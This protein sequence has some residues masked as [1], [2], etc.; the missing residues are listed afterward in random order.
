[1]H[2]R[3]SV[4]IPFMGERAAPYVPIVHDFKR[5]VHRKKARMKRIAR[6]AFPECEYKGG[7]YDILFSYLG[8][9]I[10]LTRQQFE[11]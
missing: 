10:M 9:I 7:H 2:Q 11:C 8:S 6:F 5:F 4:I 3:I 1:M